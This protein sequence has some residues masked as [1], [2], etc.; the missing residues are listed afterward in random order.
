VKLT[1]FT[2]GSQGDV[3]PCLLLGKSL[4]QAGYHVTL[5]APENFA[6]FIQG[7]GLCFHPLRG[8]VQ[9]IMASET[10]REFMEKGGTNPIQSILAMRKMIGPVAAMMAEDALAACRE[11][12]ALI[13]LAVFAPIGKSIAEIRGIP[14]IHIEPTPLLPTGDFPAPGWPVQHNLGRFLNR[15][16]GHAALQVIWQWYGPY[17]NEFRKRR[18]LRPFKGADFHRILAAAPLIGAYSPA[19]IPPPSDWPGTVHLSGYWFQEPQPGWGPAPEL[20]AFLEQGEPPVYVGFGSMSGQ[21]PETFAAIVLEALAKSGQRGLLLTGWGGMQVM[22]V[23]E[24]VFVVTSA[25]HGWL[26]PR[27]AAVVHH[28][29]AGT[30]AEGLRAGAPTVIVPFIVDQTWWGKRVEALGVGPEPIP[31]RKL[32]AD[33]LAGAIRAAVLDEGMKARA[34]ALGSR[35][36]AEDGLG[37]A[38]N[39]IRQVLRG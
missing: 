26:F 6:G 39:L 3:Q 29:G 37:N 15:L 12:E 34:A 33:T 11:A 36:R 32:D 4:Q 17:V 13:S 8:D 9:Q 21:N 5:A 16:S 25:P 14:L 7:H 24:T 27:M 18:H 10:G 23:P 19:V 38:V 31:A 22:N 20:E 35:I 2:A 1:I 28:G 30:T